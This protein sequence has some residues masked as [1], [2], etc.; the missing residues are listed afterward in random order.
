MKSVSV[1][2]TFA[3]RIILNQGILEGT[4]NTSRNG[5]VFRA[6][7]GI[8]YAKPPLGRLRFQVVFMIE[9]NLRSQWRIQEGATEIMPAPHLKNL[10]R[11]FCVMF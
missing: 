3:D 9:Q 4:T 2:G 6:Y 8:P 10:G 7:Y 5:T 1:F 11:N